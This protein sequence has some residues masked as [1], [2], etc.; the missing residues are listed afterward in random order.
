MAG[1]AP[2]HLFVEGDSR[3]TRE[4]ALYSAELIRKHWPEKPFLLITS[5]FHMRRSLA[6][7]NKVELQP[8][9]FSTDLYSNP[10]EWSPL[11]LIIP[12]S[13]SLRTWEV[14]IREWVGVISYK[15][16]GYV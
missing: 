2:D 5:A 8:V 13:G 4:N 9:A 15:V 10:W 3:N 6:C 16:A 14:L 12:S 1:V 7:F 11:D